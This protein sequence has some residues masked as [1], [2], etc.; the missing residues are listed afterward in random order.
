MLYSRVSATDRRLELR[1]SLASGRLHVWPGAFS[2]ASARM[3]EESGFGGVYVSGHMIAADLGLPDLGLTT[4]SEVA[5]RG[6][7]ITRMVDVPTL[8]DADTGFGEPLNAART[9]QTLEDAGVAGCHIEDQENPKRC[10]HADGV[11]VV[12]AD[13][14]VQRI[15]A[16]VEARRDPSFVIVARTDARAVGELGAAIER[17]QAFVEAG[18]DMVFPEALHG[19]AEYAA[20]REALDVPLMMNLNEFGRGTPP[21]RSEAAALGYNLAVYPVTLMRVALGAVQQALRELADLGSQGSLLERMQTKDELY[22]LLDHA[23]Y[24]E[25]D[26]AVFRWRR[27]E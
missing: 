20:F 24:G 6:R 25:F 1:R 10:G 13:L 15:R 26:D 22:D 14:A 19:P 5:E 27:Q 4:L 17:A 18:A 23:A 8:I 11:R 12:D 16:A 7:Q 9:I 21:S 2:V 3:I